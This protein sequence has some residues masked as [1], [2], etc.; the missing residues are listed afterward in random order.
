MES[1]GRKK[2]YQKYCQTKRKAGRENKDTK[3]QQVIEF[4][5]EEMYDLEKIRDVARL[6]REEIR[7]RL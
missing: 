6:P 3:E 2:I 5:K 1:P 7:H 4:V